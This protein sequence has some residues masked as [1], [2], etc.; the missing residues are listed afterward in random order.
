MR[1]GQDESG[2]TKAGGRSVG[3]AID[4]NPHATRS[5]A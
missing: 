5:A 2:M 3:V 1:S 4:G